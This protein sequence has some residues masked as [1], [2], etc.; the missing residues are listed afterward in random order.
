MFKIILRSTAAAV[1]LI[2]G[3]SHIAAA[4]PGRLWEVR[5][6]NS[7]TI[8]TGTSLVLGNNEDIRF[9]STTANNVNNGKISVN[10]LGNQ[11]DVIFDGTQTL[12]GSGEIVMGATNTSNRV[13]VRSPSPKAC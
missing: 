9:R 2:A 6:L 5:C 11:T 1:A 12:D 4:A 13:V 8:A 10:S 7:V 3:I